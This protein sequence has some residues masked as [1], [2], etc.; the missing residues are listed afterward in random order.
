MVLEGKKVISMFVYF[1]R[2]LIMVRHCCNLIYSLY[3]PQCV[4]IE[5]YH[6]KL[7]ITRLKR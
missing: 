1:G 5:T 7:Y 2:N 3:H 6:Y 4:I